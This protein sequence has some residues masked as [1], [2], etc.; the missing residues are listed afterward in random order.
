M[1]LNNSRGILKVGVLHAASVCATM[2]SS[3]CVELPDR[4]G[5][6]SVLFMSQMCLTSRELVSAGAVTKPSELH[7]AWAGLLVFSSTLALSCALT[8]PW[9]HWLWVVGLHWTCFPLPLHSLLESHY[10]FGAVIKIFLWKFHT[11]VLTVVASFNAD[12]CPSSHPCP[13]CPPHA[14]RFWHS[15]LYHH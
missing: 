5:H 2:K 14:L 3:H 10:Y 13:R 8:R 1:W 15:L 11:K 9:C 6:I 7:C 4:Q 12:P